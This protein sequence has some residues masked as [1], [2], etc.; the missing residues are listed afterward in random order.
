[1][2]LL[3]LSVPPLAPGLQS[4]VCGS[5]VAKKAA[6]TQV[7]NILTFADL[8]FPKTIVK[9]L[10]LNTASASLSLDC[11]PMFRGSKTYECFRGRNTLL[12]V[13][14]NELIELR[15]QA[16]DVTQDLYMHP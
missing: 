15:A 16:K 10:F 9:P 13:K 2:L 5:G 8:Y 14:G 4:L 6:G 7:S 12:S 11:Q 1:M 3:A